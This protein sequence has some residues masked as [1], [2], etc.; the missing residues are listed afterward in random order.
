MKQFYEY[1]I[2][3]IYNINIM[4]ISVSNLMLIAGD[5][6]SVLWYTSDP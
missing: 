2:G 3:L 4:G 5:N 6:Q 1:I